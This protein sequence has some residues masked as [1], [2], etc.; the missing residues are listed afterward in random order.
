MKLPT[1]LSI[2]RANDIR[3]KY[4]TDFD[5]NFCKDLSKSIAY[6]L[7]K[8]MSISKPK[9]LIGYDARLSS[10]EI[11]NVLQETFLKEG[12]GVCC[13]GVAPSPLCYFLLHHYNLSATVVVTASHNPAKDNGFKFLTHR[14]YKIT[15]P[16][17]LLKN[18][19]K[20]KS[21]L[22]LSSAEGSVFEIDATSAYISSLQKEF[23][24][25]PLPFVVDTGNGALGPLAKK[26]FAALNLFPEILFAEP[27]GR[28]PNHHPDPTIEQNLVAL[29]ERVRKSSSCFGIGFDGDGDR[30]VLVTKKGQ[31]VLG[32]ELASLFLPSLLEKQK[33]H[34]EKPAIVA[35]V[36]CSDWFF[37][38]VREAGGK[39]FMSRSG[40]GLIRQDMEKR[41]ALAGFEFS[42]HVFFN[43]RE[44]R[45][46]DDALYACLRVLELLQGES[47]LESLLPKITT[48][49]T[50]EVRLPLTN[51][52]QE[53]SLKKIKEYLLGKKESFE[54]IDGV[55]FS[56]KT[57]WGLFR[58]SKTQE[59]LTMRFEAAN[60]KELLKL[61]E[62]M[63]SV[64]NLII[65]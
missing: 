22:N 61:K 51:K 54:T 39:I 13:I 44:N 28:F 24:L 30:L 21:Y 26:T 63:S 31:T 29:K 56:R 15:D 47:S 36:K 64:L 37:K 43:D 62:E 25:K 1:S 45:R 46:L 3:G 12:L 34:P 5:L 40:H 53:E 49:R 2:F 55:R 7:K 19:Y 60:E 58:S 59:S 50:G 38:S 17:D 23:F 41:K 11:A 6:L 10:P 33:Q 14:N 16:I 65:P 8:K 20:D 48:A 32:D 18:I 4:E 9:I 42:G 35:D 27:D 57:S 52:K